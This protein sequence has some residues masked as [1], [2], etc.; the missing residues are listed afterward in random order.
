M[1]FHVYILYSEK[2]DRFYVGQ[3][4]YLQRRLSQ[5]NS[6]ES[7]YTSA[8][9][10]WT[11]LWSEPKYSRLDAEILERKLKNLSRIR[12]IGFMKKYE[13]GLIELDLLES[14]GL[15]TE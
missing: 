9:I 13:S 14:I 6:G 11:L 15:N 10:P 12:K 4:S 3:T 5:H 8:G 1:Q 2:L 7:Q